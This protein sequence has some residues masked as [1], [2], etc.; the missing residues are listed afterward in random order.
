M[1]MHVLSFEAFLEAQ[2]QAVIDK[3]YPLA[4]KENSITENLGM[5][6]RSNFKT[7]SLVGCQYPL[8]L[9]WEFY[10]LSGTPEYDHGD[11]GI[12]VKRK[13]PDGETLEGAGFLEAKIRE[14]K[15]GRFKV[16][17][18]QSKRILT[19]SPRTQLLLYD[20]NPVPVL[21]YLPDAGPWNWYPYSDHDSRRSPVSHGP[22][23]PFD[24]A[25][26]I[27]QFDGSLYRY[28]HSF[29]QQFTRRYFNLLDLES[30]G[31][32][33]GERLSRKVPGTQDHHG[34]QDSLKI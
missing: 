9:A 10:K 1:K 32:R 8:V 3:C 29:A 22:V 33:H 15:S 4:W 17:P 2:L 20:Q 26:A 23:L 13:L 34:S 30:H 11:I 21:D 24:L 25:I 19:R 18:K 28:C 16:P 5:E 31:N 6:L 27:G 14:V 12:L 7:V